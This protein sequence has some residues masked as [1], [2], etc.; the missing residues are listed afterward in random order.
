MFDDKGLR[1][2]LHDRMISDYGS[3]P[4]VLV[5]AV[6]IVAPATNGIDHPGV[7]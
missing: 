6:S 2:L 1:G 5:F 4:N 7:R 3:L